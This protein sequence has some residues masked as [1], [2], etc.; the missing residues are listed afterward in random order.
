MKYKLRWIELNYFD[1]TRISCLKLFGQLLF[2]FFPCEQW[3]S[4]DL[5]FLFV[6]V[7]VVISVHSRKVDEPQKWQ[8][9]GT[10]HAEAS[11]EVSGLS[12]QEKFS[13]WEGND[14]NAIHEWNNAPVHV[15]CSIKAAEAKRCD[16]SEH[17]LNC[18]LIWTQTHFVL[19]FVARCQ[20]ATVKNII[21]FH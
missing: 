8:T 7:A 3:C 9:W 21:S 15:S 20:S 19:S 10:K 4:F 14:C 5:F 18:W 1:F 17:Q 16:L 11:E 2:L 13:V 12:K 6:V